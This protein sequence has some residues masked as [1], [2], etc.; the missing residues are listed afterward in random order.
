MA[1]MSRL[2]ARI[3]LAI[4]LYPLAALVYLVSVFILIEG[5]D[6]YYD[7]RQRVAY[8]FL[9]AGCLTWAFMAV[10]WLL[11][12]R[13]GVRWTGGRRGLTL[14]AAFGAMA[15]A[16]LVG[17][18]AGAVVEGGF[19]WFVASV[20]APLLWLVATVLIWRESAAERAARV[21]DGGRDAVV[22]PTCGYNLTGLR[23]TRCPECGTQF[24]IDQL[25]AQQPGRAGAELQG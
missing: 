8:G 9:V 11:L 22:C 1:R 4:L 15:A 3:L 13:G 5:L 24:T 6:D 2:M 14:G 10:Y 20:T 21:G 23:E 17:G 7:Y 16:S 18:L 19:G 12:W 25:L